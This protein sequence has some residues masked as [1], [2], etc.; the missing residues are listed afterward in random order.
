VAWNEAANDGGGVSLALAGVVQNCTIVWNT[1]YYVGGIF[2]WN[3]G[4]VFNSIM[5]NNT[6]DVGDP[7]FEGQ[8]SSLCYN[9]C[10]TSNPGGIGNIVADPHFVDPLD[11]D[12]R[13]ATNSPCIDKG[14]QTAWTADVTDLDGKPRS[15]HNTVDM[16]AYEAILPAWDTDADGMPDWWM[17]KHFMHL[18]AMAEDRSRATDSADGTGTSN[19]FK[20]V[21]DLDPTNPLSVFQIVAFSNRPPNRIVWFLGSSNRVYTLNW[22]T[23][24]ASGSWANVPGQANVIGSGSLTSLSDT[25]VASSRF[26]QVSVQVP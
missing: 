14:D 22:S 26:Y 15:I 9:S 4:I 5:Y 23:N 7:N 17:W 1:A 16:G 3:G 2:C 24:L 19:L 18:T 12:F 11:G 6:A 25:N 20:Y 10:T 21:A 13:L 8:G